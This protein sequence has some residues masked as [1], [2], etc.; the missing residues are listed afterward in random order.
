MLGAVG[1]VH[2]GGNEEWGDDDGEGHVMGNKRT[3]GGHA[4][5]H[6]LS[7][8]LHV[9]LF[10]SLSLSLS[11]CLSGG[12]GRW[13]LKGVTNAFQVGVYMAFNG[14]VGAMGFKCCDGVLQRVGR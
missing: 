6:S 1:R 14:W 7:V 12:S 2:E 5:A 9:C 3:M 10:V 13:N 11:V 4:Y 8:C